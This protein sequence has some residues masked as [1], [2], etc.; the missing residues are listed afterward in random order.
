[1]TSC[2]FYWLPAS[3]DAANESARRNPTVEPKLPAGLNDRAADNWF[4]LAAIAQVAG[5][6][7]PDITLKALTSFNATDDGEEESVVIALLL[8]LRDLFKE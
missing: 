2:R 1:V 4:P 7:W 8:S 3:V 6:S 5:G